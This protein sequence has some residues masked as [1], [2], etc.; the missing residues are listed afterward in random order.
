MSDGVNNATYSYLANSPL[1]GQITLK[2]NATPRMTITKS[3]DFLNRLTA[4][5]AL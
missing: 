2:S 5:E 4:I 1:V 3:Y